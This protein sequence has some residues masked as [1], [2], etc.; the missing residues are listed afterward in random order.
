MHIILS[1]LNV[2]LFEILMANNFSYIA[3][4]L[5]IFLIIFPPSL[6]IRYNYLLLLSINKLLY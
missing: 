6:R 1:L 4:I 2:I 5:Y 3:R